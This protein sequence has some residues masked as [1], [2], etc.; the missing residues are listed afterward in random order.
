ME[1]NALEFQIEESGGKYVLAVTK[2]LVCKTRDEAIDAMERVMTVTE[3][4]FELKD[5]LGQ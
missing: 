3:S 2:R 4:F 1:E 5:E